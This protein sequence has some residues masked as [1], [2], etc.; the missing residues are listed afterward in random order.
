MPYQQFH[1]W[2]QRAT[3]HGVPTP[4]S[5]H[6]S[7][8]RFSTGSST[9]LCA[10]ALQQ[11][12][13]RNAPTRAMNEERAAPCATR[14]C[15]GLDPSPAQLS[16]LL[17]SVNVF[18]YVHTYLHARIQAKTKSTRIILLLFLLLLLL[19]LFVPSS[20]FSVSCSSS[21]SSPSSSRTSASL[22]SRLP[23][24]RYHERS[25]SYAKVCLLIKDS[26]H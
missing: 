11:P 23:S 2:H 9:R 24:P 15:K 18:T 17:L 4:L 13:I 26:K 7:R 12:P 8:G 14:S 22:S 1:L 5:A 10:Q 21:S 3:S 20:S 6:A 19:L 25:S 16:L